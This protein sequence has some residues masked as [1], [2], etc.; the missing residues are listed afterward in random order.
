[1]SLNRKRALDSIKA[2]AK[3]L[4]VVE[5]ADGGTCLSIS[6]KPKRT[7]RQTGHGLGTNRGI[8]QPDARILF[9]HLLHFN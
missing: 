9:I 3:K 7:E 2:F 4:C 1:M 8:L 6:L 5:M